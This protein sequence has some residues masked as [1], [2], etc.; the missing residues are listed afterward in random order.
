MLKYPVII[1]LALS[2]KICSHPKDHVSD[3]H[4]VYHYFTPFELYLSQIEDADDMMLIHYSYKSSSL[5][6]HDTEPYGQLCQKHNDIAF[7]SENNSTLARVIS[8]DF[9][10]IDITCDTDFDETHPHG[11]LLNDITTFY[12]TSLYPF[13][14]SGYKN[15][16]RG[17]DI[18]LDEDILT[19]LYPSGE[20]IHSKGHYYSLKSS[21]PNHPIVKKTSQLTPSDLIAIGGFYPSHL[22]NLAVIKFDKKPKISGTYD[23][24]IEFTTDEGAVVSARGTLKTL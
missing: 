17:S 5:I 9:V 21:F 2:I 8:W 11:A 4:F 24:N 23:I 10:K 18:S 20:F 14:R 12:T 22:P 15:L 7:S 6:K 13:F 16:I 1:L 3:S 19:R